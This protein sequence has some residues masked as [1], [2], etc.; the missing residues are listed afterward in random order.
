MDSCVRVWDARMLQARSSTSSASATST[1][2]GTGALATFTDIPTIHDSANAVTSPDGRFVIAGTAA[3]SQRRKGANATAGSASASGGAGDASASGPSDGRV[4]V[5]DLHALEDAA[6]ATGTGTGGITVSASAAG[7]AGSSSSSSSTSHI[8]RLLPGLSAHPFTGAGSAS[9]AYSVTACPSASAVVSLWHPRVNQIAVGCGDG[10]TR[11]LYSPSY[12]NKGALLSMGRAPKR[13]DISDEIPL[14]LASSGYG[15]IITPHALPLFRGGAGGKAAG[16]AGAS[17]G[18]AT[19]GRKRR[20]TE[21]DYRHTG[22]GGAAGG[23]VGAPSYG[24]AATSADA[25]AAASASGSASASGEPEFLTKHAKSFT[26]FFMAQQ[27]SQHVV[28][29][30]EQ[31]PTAVLR[32][33]AAKVQADKD[34]AA[35]TAAYAK[36][37][38]K[39][40]L[41]ERTLEQ[42]VEDAK[43]ETEALLRGNIAGR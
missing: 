7:G 11:I 14:A 1:G 27:T 32:E 15:K 37:Q 20:F 8:S 2:T 23:G 31:D 39:A 29:L 18:A 21:M 41:M 3:P 5:F 28:N 40:V 42:E 22:E 24:P 10:A 9:N 33:Y 26:Q 13:R 12:S 16:G 38:P 30:R 36:T 34:G 35:F 4:Y 17:A 19:A 43:R 25:A 6:T